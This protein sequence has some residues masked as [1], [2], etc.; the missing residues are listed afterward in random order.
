[1]YVAIKA[2]QFLRLIQKLFQDSDFH[3]SKPET[4]KSQ[5]ES[6]HLN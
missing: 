3:I 1:M 2:V 4:L 6:C 5:L